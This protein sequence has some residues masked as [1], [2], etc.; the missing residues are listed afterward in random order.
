MPNANNRKI[1]KSKHGNL[2]HGDLKNGKV[3]WGY[4]NLSKSGYGVAEMWYFPEAFERKK[5]KNNE[6]AGRFAKTEAGMRVKRKSVLKKFGLSID[7]YNK[8]LAKQNGVCAICKKPET[9][10]FFKNL[11]VDHCHSTGII[12][13]L[14]CN[15]CNTC[16]GKFED[17]IEL[18]HAAIKYI[19]DN[20]L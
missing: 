13:G 3:F 6:R 9:V 4:N 7:E 20:S 1:L 15:R 18:F 2:K 8:I 11:A 19:T 17:K 14:L 5:K 12:R 16:I 10:D